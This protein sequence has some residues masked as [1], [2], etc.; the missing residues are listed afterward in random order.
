MDKV[1][2]KYI[3]K[4]MDLVLAMRL[5]SIILSQVYNIPFIAISYSTKTDEIIEQIKKK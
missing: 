5:H 1:Y 3:Y 4:E 2:A